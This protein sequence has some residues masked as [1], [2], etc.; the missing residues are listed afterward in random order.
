MFPLPSYSVHDV[1]SHNKSD[2]LWV[3]IDDKVFDLTNYMHEHPGGKKVSI[4]G[5]DAT[6]K[7]HK[8]H[9][10]SAMTKYGDTLCVGVLEKDQKGKGIF[11]RM[12]SSI[13]RN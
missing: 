8:Y 3:I 1:A 13:F 12:I 10:P 6:K 9:R 4:G 2:D 11:H 5:S 7:Y